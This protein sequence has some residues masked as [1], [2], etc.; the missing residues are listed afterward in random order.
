MKL[1]EVAGDQVQ[2]RFHFRD[3][4]PQWVGGAPKRNGDVSKGWWSHPNMLRFRVDDT[5]LPLAIVTTCTNLVCLA[6]EQVFQ[7]VEE[8]KRQRKLVS[9]LKVQRDIKQTEV[10]KAQQAEKDTAQ[11]VRATSDTQC[12]KALR[13]GNMQVSQ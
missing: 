9:L 13:Y 8:E 5:S 4:P 2:E 1:P 11:Q 10:V 6:A 12:F 7:W 3:P